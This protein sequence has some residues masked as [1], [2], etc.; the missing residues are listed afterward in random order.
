MKSISEVL[1]VP[2]NQ[3]HK[4]PSPPEGPG[5]GASD[6]TSLSMPEQYPDASAVMEELSSVG[7]DAGGV[8]IAITHNSITCAQKHTYGKVTM[9]MVASEYLTSEEKPYTW[10]HDFLYRS[11]NFIVGGIKNP[12]NVKCEDEYHFRAYVFLPKWD[13]Y[14]G[15]MSPDLEQITE[16]FDTYAEAQKWV[17]NSWQTMCQLG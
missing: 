16:V 13:K 4:T 11:D 3:D 2:A 8:S 12:W 1:G 15:R 17:E 14:L 9:S 7:T 6:A 5:G 10:K